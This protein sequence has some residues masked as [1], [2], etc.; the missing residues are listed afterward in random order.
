VK[1]I[2]YIFVVLIIFVS[3]KD[4]EIITKNWEISLPLT[5][6]PLDL[7]QWGVTK[8][9]SLKLRN[10]PIEES[11]IVN[12]LPLGAVVEVIKKE[13]EIKNFENTLDY[14]YFIDY[15]G[16]NGWIFGSYLEIFNTY[17]EAIKRSEEILFGK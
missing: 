13:K 9:S 4:K 16:E 2:I 7:N 14:W 6:T 8:Y 3:C 10:S 5:N 1:K 15:E 17:D 12:H 11:T